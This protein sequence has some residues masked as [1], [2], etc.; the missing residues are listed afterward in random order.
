[1]SGGHTPWCLRSL[2]LDLWLLGNDVTLRMD[3][4]IPD[5]LPARLQAEVQD[6][7][8]FGIRFVRFILQV[9][10]VLL[11]ATDPPC[12]PQLHWPRLAILSEFWHVLRSGEILVERL[13][14]CGENYF[15][16]TLQVP[17]SAFA[18]GGVI[19]IG[20]ASS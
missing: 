7:L 4:V 8:A 3:Q 14:P 18:E 9:A 11:I 10:A 15:C 1:M 2:L 16:L 6:F 19:W 13:E 20:S 5:L 17:R 12:V